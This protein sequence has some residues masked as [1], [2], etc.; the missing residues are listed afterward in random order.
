MTP[1]FALILAAVAS[2]GG[3]GAAREGQRSVRESGVRTEARAAVTILKS[4]IIDFAEAKGRGE[5]ARIRR[6][7]DGTVW[8]EF[9]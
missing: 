9:S 1:A 3:D 4:E 6:D 5:G 8:L 2:Q 7:A